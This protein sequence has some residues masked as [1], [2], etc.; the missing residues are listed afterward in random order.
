MAQNC[1]NRTISLHLH[2]CGE[3]HCPNSS[4]CYHLNKDKYEGSLIPTDKFRRTL[5][6]SGYKVHESICITANLYY[7]NI[8]L[9]YYRSYNITISRDDLIFSGINQH[10]NQIQVTVYNEEQARELVR[11]QKLFLIK[12]YESLQLGIHLMRSPVGRIHLIIEQGYLERCPEILSYLIRANESK[13]NATASLDTCLTSWVVNGR[14]PYETNYID[15][16]YDNTVR[17]CPYQKEGYIF[18]SVNDSF[19]NTPVRKDCIYYKLFQRKNDERFGGT[20][21]QDSTTDNGCGGCTKR[22]R[23]FS[24]RS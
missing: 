5:L 1:S 17:K 24:L 11:H 4:V 14:C 22:R 21:I 20:D 7:F 10:L 19:V 9:K 13:A 12:D 16:T 6:D 8:L 3:N 23:R 15:I 18:T 2:K